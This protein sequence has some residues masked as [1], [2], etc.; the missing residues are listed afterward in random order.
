MFGYGVVLKARIF[1][2]CGAI[3]ELNVKHKKND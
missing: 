1:Y 3:E 2:R